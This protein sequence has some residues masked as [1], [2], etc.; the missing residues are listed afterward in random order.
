MALTL[1]KVPG[2]LGGD[3]IG[4]EGACGRSL[5][6][7][8]FALSQLG[9]SYPRWKESELLYSA[10]RPRPKGSPCSIVTGSTL[11]PI[12]EQGQASGSSNRVE[13][14][15]WEGISGRGLGAV[16]LVT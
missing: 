10:G 11:Q 3:Y 1:D 4:H 8:T 14:Q 15:V 7:P 5:G 2:L 12:G 6:R 13:D 9:G 16:P